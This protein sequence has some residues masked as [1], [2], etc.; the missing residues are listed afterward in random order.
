MVVQRHLSFHFSNLHFLTLIVSFR[1][2]LRTRKICY[3]SAIRI[4]SMI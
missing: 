3:F 1:E 4:L 2:I